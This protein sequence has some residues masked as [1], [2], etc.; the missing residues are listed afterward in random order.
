MLDRTIQALGVDRQ[1]D[2]DPE[3]DG[4]SDECPADVLGV[5]IRTG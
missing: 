2:S 1:F 3:L 4:A 5:R